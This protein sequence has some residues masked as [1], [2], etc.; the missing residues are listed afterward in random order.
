M[1]VSLYR[2]T[3]M[4]WESN[5]FGLVI[6]LITSPLKRPLENLLIHYR[7]TTLLSLAGFYCVARFVA[8]RVTAIVA[9]TIVALLFLRFPSTW[10]QFEFMMV[11]HHYANSSALGCIGLMLVSACRKGRPIWFIMAGAPFVLAACWPHQL[12]AANRIP[13]TMS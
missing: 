13:T 2:R 8:D 4:Y 5:R 6:P 11:Q 7:I 9:G 3:P 10:R 12:P 1:L